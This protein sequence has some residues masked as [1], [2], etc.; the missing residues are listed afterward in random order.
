MAKTYRFQ[1]TA[2]KRK[3]RR[4]IFINSSYSLQTVVILWV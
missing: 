2:T 3:S 1:Q 4:L